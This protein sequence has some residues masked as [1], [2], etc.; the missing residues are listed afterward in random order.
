MSAAL[1]SLAALLFFW[2][3]A[4]LISR[5]LRLRFESEDSRR[6]R[7]MIH[8]QAFFHAPAHAALVMVLSLAGATREIFRPR[9]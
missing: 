4:A 9:K 8:A 7:A 5:R 3:L 6:A 1:Y 2:T